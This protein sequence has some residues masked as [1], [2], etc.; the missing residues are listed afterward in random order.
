MFRPKPTAGYQGYQPDIS[1]ISTPFIHRI[2]WVVTPCVETSVFTDQNASIKKIIERFSC[3]FS[4]V[5]FDIRMHR[6]LK[7][8]QRSMYTDTLNFADKFKVYFV[9]HGTTMNV[10]K[11]ARI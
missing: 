6:R 4:E 2:S 5:E 10:K 7:I 11:H 9:L 1:R 8:C 3:T